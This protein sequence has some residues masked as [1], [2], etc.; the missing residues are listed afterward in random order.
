VAENLT[1]TVALAGSGHKWM[2]QPRSQRIFWVWGLLFAGLLAAL[3]LELMIGVVYIPFSEILSSLFTGESERATWT[4]IVIQFRLPRAVNAIVSGG[5]LGACGLLLQTLFRNPLADPYVLGVVHGGRVGAA[6][7]VVLAGVAG[8]LYSDKFGWLGDLTLAVAAAAGS[9]LVMLAITIMA[10][11]VSTVTLLI[12]GL[13]LGYL[14]QG[15]VS[16]VLHFTDETQAGAFNAWNDGSYAGISTRQLQILIPLVIAGVAMA[17]AL[18]KPLNALQLGENYAGSL[19][20]NV[21]RVRIWAFVCTAI[22]AGAVTAYCGPIA[23]VG[24]VV[25]HLCRILF[26]T[27]DHRILMPACVLMGGFMALST[28]LVTHLPWSK[29]FL[30]LN[31]VNG[32]LGAPLVMLL[33]ARR[34]NRR[35]LEM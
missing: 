25:A 8:N 22:L 30:H 5:A 7:L 28:D 1:N 14:C 15:L 21:L 4:R 35:A 34:R 23:F 32:L 24:L 19:G 3:A 11:R 18:V 20:V 6:V 29:H 9:T 17:F 33:I 12:F 10:R 16:V 13:M 31:A 2:I 26:Q 27:S